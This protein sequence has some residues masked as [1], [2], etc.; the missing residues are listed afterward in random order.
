MKN[1]N[2]CCIRNVKGTNN[3]RQRKI[4]KRTF[5]LRS[6]EQEITDTIRENFTI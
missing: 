6:R 3:L 1:N 4:V 5:I 2:K